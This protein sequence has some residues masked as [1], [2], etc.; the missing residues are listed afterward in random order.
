MLISIRCEF[1]EFYLVLATIFTE[2]LV[3]F[4]LFKYCTRGCLAILFRRNSSFALGVSAIISLSLTAIPIVV[5]LVAGIFLFTKKKI[6]NTTA[7][8]GKKVNGRQTT[9]I[10]QEH[11]DK[12]N[13]EH[14]KDNQDILPNSSEDQKENLSKNSHNAI[15]NIGDNKKND[16]LINLNDNNLQMANEVNVPMQ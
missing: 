8:S 15:N 4:R 12:E 1:F 11:N 16:H 2:F 3:F 13:N 6:K 5:L 9:A 7:Y 10:S 14:N